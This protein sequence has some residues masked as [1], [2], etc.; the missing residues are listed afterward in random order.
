[1]AKYKQN[2]IINIITLSPVTIDK[3]AN[4]EYK[5]MVSIS[6]NNAFFVDPRIT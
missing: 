5:I 1:M 3:S 4:E 6:T 2:I